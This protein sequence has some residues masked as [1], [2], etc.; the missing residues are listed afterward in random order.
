MIFRLLPPINREYH[1]RAED[2]HVPERNRQERFDTALMSTTVSKR[3]MTIAMVK[4]SATITVASPAPNQPSVR[5]TLTLWTRASA[6]GTMKKTIQLEKAAPC[7]HK[8]N[9]LGGLAWKRLASTLLLNPQTTSPANT[10][11]MQK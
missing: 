10:S 1:Q 11:D 9:G 7:I 6:D 8:S 2:D 3:V 5:W 4:P